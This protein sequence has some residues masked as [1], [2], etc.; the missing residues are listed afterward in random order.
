MLHQHTTKAPYV[1]DILTPMKDFKIK[2]G[3]Y[4]LKGLEN[5]DVWLVIDGKAILQDSET[6]AAIIFRGDSGDAL[7]KAMVNAGAVRQDD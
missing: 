7:V 6:I 5:A 1:C 2:R 4:N 3:T